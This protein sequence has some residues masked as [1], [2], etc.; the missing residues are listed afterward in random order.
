MPD[1]LREKRLVIV[2]GLS[3]AG[4]TVA[5]HALED[6]GYYCIDNLPAGFLK[7]VV[8]DLVF[9]A[10]GRTSLLAVGIDARNR[11]ADLA[12]LPALINAYR[13]QDLATDVV[14]IKAG[15]DVL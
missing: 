15:R 3:G 12:G 6:L 10:N 2:S 5:L 13:R 8:D 4:K 11:A 14:Y 9:D 1:S 7:A